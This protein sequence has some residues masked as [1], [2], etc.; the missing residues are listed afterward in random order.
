VSEFA[1]EQEVYERIGR[2]LQELAADP[3]LR[4]VFEAADT[5]VRYELHHPD[6]AITVSSR[7]GAPVRVDFGDSDQEPE[8]VISMDADVAHS[9]LLGEVDMTVALARGQ[10]T[11]E[12]PVTKILAVLPAFEPLL[13]RYRAIVSPPNG[14]G[15]ASGDEAPGAGI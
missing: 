11:A 5:C 3:E 13:P 2:V 7:G 1:D 14:G 15:S 8:I 10:V 9:Y 12:G 6:A 4:P